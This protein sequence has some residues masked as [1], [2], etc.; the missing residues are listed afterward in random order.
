V[1]LIYED[2]HG[3][4]NRVLFPKVGEWQTNEV[5]DVD[6]DVG[7][8]LLKHHGAFIRR[9]DESKPKKKKVVETKNAI[10]EAAEKV[11]DFYKTEDEGGEIYCHEDSIHTYYYKRKL[12]IC[13]VPLSWM[14]G[15]GVRERN[16]IVR[17]ISTTKR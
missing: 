16:S 13:Q 10:E 8:F 15:A 7:E 2:P 9:A 14:V 12:L 5:K 6:N 1:K 17:F 11:E 3:R 4:S